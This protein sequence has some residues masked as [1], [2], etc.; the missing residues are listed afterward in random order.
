MNFSIL[1]KKLTNKVFL[2]FLIIGGLNT[3]FGYL[4]F[5]V[6]TFLLGNAYTSVVLSTVSGVLFNFKT[7][8][9]LVFK[10]HDNSRIFRFFAS[11][12][13]LI[14]IQMILLKWLNFL[15]ITNPYL[16]VAILILPMSALS[17]VILRK[18]VFHTALIPETINSSEKSST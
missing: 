2:K 13:F 11:Y 5:C 17:F 1:I 18:F 4:S 10:S 9:S 6:F 12:L 8:G 16:A 3:A 14:G 15:G 7:Y